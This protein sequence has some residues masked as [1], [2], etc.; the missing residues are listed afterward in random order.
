MA[1]ADT[2]RSAVVGAGAGTARAK[3]ALKAALRKAGAGSPASGVSGMR[4]AG[5]GADSTWRGAGATFGVFLRG[6]VVGKA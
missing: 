1:G 3:G 4:A 2:F 6:A 5:T